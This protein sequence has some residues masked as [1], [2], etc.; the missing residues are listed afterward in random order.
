MA[1]T[2]AGTYDNGSCCNSASAFAGYV[3][4][5]GTAAVFSLDYASGTAAG[6]SNEAG[7]RMMT[8]YG[9]VAAN[10]TVT[11]TASSG[12]T[13]ASGWKFGTITWDTADTAYTSW[14]CSNGLYKKNYAAGGST[15]SNG[16]SNLV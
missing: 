13:A 11:G 15:P 4:T 2:Q 5:T 1:L 6:A 12:A 16:L 14:W 3:G 10:N 9:C 7:G 8:K